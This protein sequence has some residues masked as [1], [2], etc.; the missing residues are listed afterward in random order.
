MIAETANDGL[1]ALLRVGLRTLGAASSLAVR[2]R[3]ARFRARQAALRRRYAIAPDTPIR[4]FDAETRR[5]IEAFAAAHPDA[6]FATTSGSTGEA[7]R[8]AYTRARLRMIKRE[9]LSAT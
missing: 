7:K 4:G 5:S 3:I 1:R 9:N 2:L 6:R 8:V